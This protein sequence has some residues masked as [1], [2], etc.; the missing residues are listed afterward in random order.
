MSFFY[1]ESRAE[2]VYT[3]HKTDT[4]GSDT[5]VFVS[6][7]Y[8]QQILLTTSENTVVL[9]QRFCKAETRDSL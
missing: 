8:I 7:M 2:D 5:S 1:F 3:G 4:Y 9:L 6:R